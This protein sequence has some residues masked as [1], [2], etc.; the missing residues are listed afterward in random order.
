MKNCCVV[1]VQ[2]TRWQ[3]PGAAVA[4]I[5]RAWTAFH[6]HRTVLSTMSTQCGAR[7][8]IA[9]I[10]LDCAVN[11]RFSQEFERSQQLNLDGHQH[12]IGLKHIPSLDLSLSPIRLLHGHAFG[13]T[14]SNKTRAGPEVQELTYICCLPRKGPRRRHCLAQ[15]DMAYLILSLFSLQPCI[16]Q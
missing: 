4:Q 12:D 9:I 2:S 8:L 16:A 14:Q 7:L 11:R 13:A 6:C 10:L 5:T 1:V 3:V 15:A